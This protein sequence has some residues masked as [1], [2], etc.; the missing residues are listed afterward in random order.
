[1]SYVFDI[2]LRECVCPNCVVGL[3]KLSS[4]TIN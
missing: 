1:M 4:E 3:E 2:E